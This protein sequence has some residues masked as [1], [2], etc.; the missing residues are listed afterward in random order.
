V[1]AIELAHRTEE[2]VL[3]RT[4]GV[5]ERF[6]H[7]L[8][9]LLLAK[10]QPLGTA[11]IEV[12]IPLKQHEVAHLLAATPEHLNRLIRKMQ[13][14]GLI[15]RDKGCLTVLNPLQLLVSLGLSQPR[16]AAASVQ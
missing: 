5:R 4:C 7:F 3:L 9:Q 6:C 2:Q 8:C 14:E 16:V 1:L 11:P 15:I 13:I 10:G 12:E